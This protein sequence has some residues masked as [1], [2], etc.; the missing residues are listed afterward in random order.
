VKRRWTDSTASMSW[1]VNGDQMTESCSRSGLTYTVNARASKC[2]LRLTKVRQIAAD[3]LW[4]F[5]TMSLTCREG[6]KSH[7]TRT[8][9]SRVDSTTGKALSF[10]WRQVSWLILPTFNTQHL[11]TEMDNCHSVAQLT[12]ALYTT[13][14]G[15]LWL[16]LQKYTVILHCDVINP[17]LSKF[18]S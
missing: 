18:Q 13:H 12:K 4:A 9:K 2:I 17:D 6:D 8:P 16:Y 14:V 15:E 11:L 7:D 10:I 5:A 1:T 3:H